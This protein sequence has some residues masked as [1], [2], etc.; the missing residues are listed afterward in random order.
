MK[1]SLVESRREYEK[2]KGETE[3]KNLFIFN[4]GPIIVFLKCRPAREQLKMSSQNL[5]TKTLAQLFP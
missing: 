1:L 2:R 3:T 5:V 4:L